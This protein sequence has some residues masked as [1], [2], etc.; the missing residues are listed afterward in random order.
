MLEAMGHGI[1][2]LATDVG[3]VSELLDDGRCGRVVA[4]RA[5]A[6]FADA[7]IELAANA[8]Q[9]DA[10]AQA[11]YD[12]VMAVH[13]PAAVLPAWLQAYARV[14]GTE[15]PSVEHLCRRDESTPR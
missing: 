13:S 8:V 1:P 5:H 10:F 9:R 12:R 11:G 7:I 15:A 2:V 4:A 6:A 3:G 14:L